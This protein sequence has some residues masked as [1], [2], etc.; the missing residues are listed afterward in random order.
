MTTPDV[1]GVY[2]QGIIHREFQDL[3][4]VLKIWQSHCVSYLVAQHDADEK[5]SRTHCH[6][7][8]GDSDVGKEQLRRI[9][10]SE[11]K[12]L[13]RRD[14]FILE[15]NMKTKEPYDRKKL[16]RY[17]LKGTCPAYLVKNISDEEI[18]EARQSWAPESSEAPELVK[19]E[20]KKDDYFEYCIEAL[21]TA[22]KEWF[23]TDPQWDVWQD[24]GYL[25]FLRSLRE[26]CRS[27]F[28]QHLAC[29]L[30]KKRV[31]TSSNEFERFYVTCMRLVDG[32]AKSL[33]SRLEAK[34]YIN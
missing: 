23:R 9:L 27:R 28:M 21:N 32:E 5:V 13:D 25:P 20:K 33:F 17:I 3:S 14:A 15:K 1:S 34:L 18:A 7:L 16:L 4:G 26:E 10:K 29:Y 8:I 22:P 19:K 30:N 31:R 2:W 6:I 11:I 24:E 12:D